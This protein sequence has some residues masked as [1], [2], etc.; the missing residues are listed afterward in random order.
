M[1]GRFLFN[2]LCSQKLIAWELQLGACA[3]FDEASN[4]NLRSL[5][6]SEQVIKRAFHYMLSLSL[7][8]ILVQ[9]F[10]FTKKD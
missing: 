9:P 4:E 8:S 1:V 5:V 7:T 2:I 6:S 10:D 3:G